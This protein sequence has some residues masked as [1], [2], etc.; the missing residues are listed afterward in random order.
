LSAVRKL[1]EKTQLRV[2]KLLNDMRSQY[3]DLEIQKQIDELQEK[4]DRQRDA[5]KRHLA[6]EVE[7]K[8]QK[9]KTEENSE[10]KP[11]LVLSDGT[12]FDPF[13]I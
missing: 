9:P 11:P 8:S 10:P 3:D 5:M 13:S 2:Q 6:K 12:K 7:S 4:L 1:G